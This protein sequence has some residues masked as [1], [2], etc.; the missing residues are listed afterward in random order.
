MQNH[1]P[2]TITFQG[3]HLLEMK[4][5]FDKASPLAQNL[6]KKAD[7]LLHARAL[8]VVARGLKS[9]LG[10]EHDYMSMGPYWWPN[11][12]TENGLPYIRKDGEIN[13][14]TITEDTYGEMTERVLMLALAAFLFENKN[15]AQKAEE[16]LHVWHL[17]KETYMRPHLEYGQA[18]PGICTGRGIGLID[19]SGSYRLFDA[20]AMLEYMGYISDKT[21][22]GIKNWYDAFLNWM[23]TS[24]NGI[25]EGNEK[26]NHGTWYDVQIASIA[27]FLEKTDLA[28]KTLELAYERRLVTQVKE[29]GSQPDELSRT[30]GMHYSFYNLKALLR[31]A[32]MAEQ[33]DTKCDYWA[34]TKTGPS[35]LRRAIDFLYPYTL[36]LSN[37]PYQ[38]I[39]GTVPKSSVAEALMYAEARFPGNG[40]AKKAEQ[41]LDDTMLW[42]LYPRM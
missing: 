9:E 24:Q 32:S 36:D 3:K 42:Q 4:S 14:E 2:K 41:F 12:D 5:T 20:I 35:L 37:F 1:Y 31:L 18:I 27:L 26:N 30:K 11:P 16:C 22:E 40:Y 34:N 15:Y 28:T 39:S 19:T 10:D 6:K 13:P 23:L 38:E 33:V 21:L 8:N 29:D 7:E 25:D 17:N